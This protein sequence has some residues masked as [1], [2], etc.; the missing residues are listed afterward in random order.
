VILVK[1]ECPIKVNRVLNACLRSL[2]V[3]GGEEGV[4]RGVVAA[5]TAYQCRTCVEAGKQIIILVSSFIGTQS[6]S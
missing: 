2:T 3:S 4:Q 1:I 5:P 6:V